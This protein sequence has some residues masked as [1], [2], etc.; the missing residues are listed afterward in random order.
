MGEERW[1]SLCPQYP[2]QAT[3]LNQVMLR[4]GKI[5]NVLTTLTSMVRCL[6]LVGSTNLEEWGLKVRTKV[7]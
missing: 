4:S 2:H 7:S 6:T 3:T 1:R 5:M